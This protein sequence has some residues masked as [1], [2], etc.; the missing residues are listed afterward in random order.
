[1]D[2]ENT[3]S[4]V[5]RRKTHEAIKN[6]YLLFQAGDL[7][8][9]TTRPANIFT[10]EEIHVIPNKKLAIFCSYFTEGNPWVDVPA[11]E[12]LRDFAIHNETD[13]ALF[14]IYVRKAERNDFAQWSVEAQKIFMSDPNVIMW[15]VPSF[16]NAIVANHSCQIKE[17][18]PS[19]AIDNDPRY[20]WLDDT[21]M[22]CLEGVK[23]MHCHLLLHELTTHLAIHRDL[24]ASDL[25]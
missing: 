11:S 20:M 14:G 2:Q 10:H 8:V 15:V 6:H 23:K 21:R 18:Q 7:S 17:D 5:L 9:F 3:V 1:M 24:F 19:F 13:M 4:V 25:F 12:V 22:T 16:F